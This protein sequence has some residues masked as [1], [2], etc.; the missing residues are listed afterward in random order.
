[1]TEDELIKDINKFLM[2]N[3]DFDYGN[4]KELITTKISKCTQIP[5]SEKQMNINSLYNAAINRRL[6]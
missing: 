3:T 1:M 6:K 5:D 2:E 4:L